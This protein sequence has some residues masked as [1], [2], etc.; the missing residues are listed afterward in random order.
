MEVCSFKYLKSLEAK[1]CPRDFEICKFAFQN[2]LKEDKQKI[3]LG[4][5]RFGGIIFKYSQS[6]LVK[7]CPSYIQISN[8]AFS[9]IWKGD[10][11]KIALGFLKFASMVF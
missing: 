10:K 5:L 3:F 2:F 9:N 4:I 1:N 7:N 8:Y 6:V 11:Q